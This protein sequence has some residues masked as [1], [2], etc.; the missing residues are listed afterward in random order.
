MIMK[1][2]KLKF[3]MTKRTTLLMLSGHLRQAGILLNLFPIKIILKQCKRL[4]IPLKA[5]RDYTVKYCMRNETILKYCTNV[6]HCL[7]A[8]GL[9]T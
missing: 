8:W 6:F 2:S 1:T 4:F 9:S 7:R 5:Q 3:A